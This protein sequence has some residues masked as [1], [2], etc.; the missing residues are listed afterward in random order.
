MLSITEN[1]IDPKCSTGKRKV[2]WY[3]DKSM[4]LWAIGHVSARHNVSV[5]DVLVFDVDIDYDLLKLTRWRGVYTCSQVIYTVRG[6][7]LAT[8]HLH[9][10][11]MAS[12][13]WPF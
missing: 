10:T 3:V 5:A 6:F 9:N 1:G 7:S 4:L 2:S 8:M 11:F 12:E 13:E